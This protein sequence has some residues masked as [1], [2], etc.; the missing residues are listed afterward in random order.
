MVGL[1]PDVV[2]KRDRYVGRF[3]YRRACVQLY[4]TYAYIRKARTRLAALRPKRRR[5]RTEAYLEMD[6]DN[7]AIPCTSAFPLPPRSHRIPYI[8]HE[9]RNLIRT[10]NH[11]KRKYSG[12]AHGAGNGGGG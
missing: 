6:R 2:N 4:G 9:S 1:Y 8:Y 11:E 5:G 12:H 7:V 3:T 10:H